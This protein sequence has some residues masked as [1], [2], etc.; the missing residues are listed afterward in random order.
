MSEQTTGEGPKPEAAELRQGD[1]LE[2][3]WH[4][5]DH[6]AARIGIVLGI[7]VA[8]LILFPILAQWMF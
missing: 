1:P 6:P 7:L 3:L 5:S 4:W 2:G 8:S